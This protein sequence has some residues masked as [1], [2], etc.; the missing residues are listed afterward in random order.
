M[1]SIREVQISDAPRLVEIY[2][3]YVMNTAVSF[4]YV[5]PTADEF[6]RRIKHTT[7]KYPYLV[8]VDDGKVV[9]YAY[10]GAYSTRQ[11]YDWTATTSIYVDMEYRTHNS[12]TF[13]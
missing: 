10:A 4:E 12:H 8:C 5:V 1:L 9:G 7:E 13:H 6:E 11:A 2:S 3:Y